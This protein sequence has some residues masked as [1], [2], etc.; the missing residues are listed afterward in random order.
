M[1]DYIWSD[2]LTTTDTFLVTLPDTY[3]V[4]ITDTNLCAANDII[5]VTEN[6]LPTPNLGGPVSSCPGDTVTLDAGVGYSAYLWSDGSTNQTLVTSVAGSYDVTV[7]DANG[8][9]NSAGILFFNDT[10]PLINIGADDSLCDGGTKV[11][12]AG[13]GPFTSYLWSNGTTNQT[14]TF[15]VT[16][17]PWVIVEDTNGCV[18]SDTMHL[19]IF[20]LPNVNLGPDDFFCVNDSA[21]LNAGA[22]FTTY[23]WNNGNPNQTLVV[24]NPGTYSVTVEDINQCFDSDTILVSQVPLPTVNIGPDIEYCTGS[25]FNQ[26]LNAGNGFVLYTWMDGT[27]TQIRNID[28]TYDTVWV[29]VLDTN[30]CRNVDTMFVI[31]NLLPALNLGP[32][33]TICSSQIYSLNAGNPNG[34]I[35]SYL[36]STGTTNQ[37]INIGPNSG[38]QNDSTGYYSVTITDNKGCQSMDTMALFT[39]ALPQPNL[40]NDT[41]FCTGDPFTMVLDPGAFVS[42]NWNNGAITPTITIPAVGTSYSVTVTD[43]NGCSNSDG[44]VVTDNPLPTPNL[45]PD[46]DFCEGTSYTKILNPGNFTTYLW[47]DGTTAKVL[48]VSAGGIYSVTVT[49]NNGCINQDNIVI[50]ENPAPVVNLGADVFYCEDAVIAHILNATAGL[51]GPGFNFIWNTGATSGTIIANNFG[52]Y[53]VTVTDQVTNCNTVSDMEIKAT[54]KA[55]PQLGTDGVICEGQLITLDPNVDIPGY[56]YTWSTGATTAT[57]NVFETGIY[58]VRLDAANGTCLG[59]TDTIRYDPG[60]LPV[61]ELGE[62]LFPCIGQDVILLNNVTDFPGTT[63]EW[64]DG[65]EGGNYVAQT[66][67]LYEVEATNTCG[68]VIDQVFIEFQD[69]G[70]VYVPSAFSPNGDGRNDFFAPKSDQ[71]FVEYGFWIYDRWGQLMF[72]TNTPNVGWNGAVDGNEAPTGVYVWRLSYVSAFQ[73]VGNRTEKMGEI[74]LIR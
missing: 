29:E 40:G 65:T 3:S 20:P 54:L 4:T 23:S 63:Y 60:V 49:D 17:D 12:N 1:S 70:N 33:D 42:Y 31:E 44:I 18:G 67:G 55:D 71:E 58:W 14:A 21:I 15:S 48:G 16:S 64:Q 35:V 69:C 51:P 57:I 72:K 26:L 38:Q 8:C 50:T 9:E 39:Y 68:S 11:L 10:I 47:S 41:A 52:L 37:T 13:A 5:I 73:E 43:V 7:T 32:D 24:Y 56:N 34:A 36:W 6:P 2:G 19:E 62:D 53:S 45:G 30:G 59:I 61:L 66:T 46:E 22:G 25:T 28:Q 27:F 74:T